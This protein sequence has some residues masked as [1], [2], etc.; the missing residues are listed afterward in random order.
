MSR[1]FVDSMTKGVAMVTTTDHD[2]NPIGLSIPSLASFSID[3]PSV[4]LSASSDFTNLLEGGD[5]GV[6]LLNTD[7]AMLAESTW[8][9]ATKLHEVDWIRSVPVIPS[10]MA[11]MVCYPLVA[12]DVAGVTLVVAEVRD[13]VVEDGTPLLH[14]AGI[15]DRVGVTT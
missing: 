11:R 13:V 3:P 12:E 6:S 15:M 8:Q 10:A 7:H 2:G 4:M 9:Q 1:S 5:F 14:H